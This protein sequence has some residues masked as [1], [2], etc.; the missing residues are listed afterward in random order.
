MPTFRNTLSV[1]SS[2]AEDGTDRMFRNVGIQNS[3]TG[4]LPRR[5]RTTV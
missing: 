2:Q 3:D 4:E 1:P 5:K